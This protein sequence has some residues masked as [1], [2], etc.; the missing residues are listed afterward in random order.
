MIFFM[1]RRLW[2]KGVSLRHLTLWVGAAFF[3]HVAAMVVFEGMTPFEAVWLTATTI[4]TVGYGDY[5]PK[6][7]A[8][9]VATMMLYAAGIFT[10]AAAI[11][12]IQEA[13][14][15]RRER[16]RSGQWKWK[17]KDHIVFVSPT[18]G[19]H[20][21]FVA[22]VVQELR[23]AGCTQHVLMLSIGERDG[24]PARFEALD[25][26]IVRAS[27]LDDRTIAAA[28]L[29]DCHTTVL[30][31]DDNPVTG[32]AF[33]VDTLSRLQGHSKCHFI[34]EAVGEDE[35]RIKRLGAERVVRPFRVYP[36]LLAREIVAPGSA[37]I[38]Q[39][40]FSATGTTLVRVDFATTV[41]ERWDDIVLRMLRAG[42]GTPIAL[43]HAG[44]G[45][46]CDPYPDQKYFCDA[47]YVV[48]TDTKRTMESVDKIRTLIT[49]HA[50]PDF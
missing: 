24:L 29:T 47:L 7:E 3:A 37:G 33:V 26:A 16:K 14:A 11:N 22:D 32:S 43:F 39:E 9:R 12:E 48:A 41:F 15:I 45:V 40:L 1:R 35:G 27:K 23:A 44:E 28:C 6:T 4:V 36:E 46:I 21:D 2:F 5:S 19:Q 13:S 30:L 49:T 38:V 50:A 25:I 34:V 42:Y 18:T 31:D 10:L 20:E 17:M 8:G